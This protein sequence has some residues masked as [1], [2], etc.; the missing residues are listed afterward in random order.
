ME[1]DFVNEYV[2]KW[3]WFSK[4]FVMNKIIGNIFVAYKLAF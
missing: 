4:N 3:H 1:S 2:K